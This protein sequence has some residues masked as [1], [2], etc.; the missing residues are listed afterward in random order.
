M[1]VHFYPL[2]IGTIALNPSMELVFDMPPSRFET[3][4]F[5][6]FFMILSQQKYKIQDSKK[7]DLREDTTKNRGN[8]TPRSAFSQ[9]GSFIHYQII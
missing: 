6:I 2:R 1:V 9:T 5:F 8:K 3:S 7:A 4:C